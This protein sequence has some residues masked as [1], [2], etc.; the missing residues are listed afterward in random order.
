MGN[1]GFHVRSEL[2]NSSV[3]RLLLPWSKKELIHFT[4]CHLFTYF[5][6][7]HSSHLCL[8]WCYTHMHSV[9]WICYVWNGMLAFYA[10]YTVFCFFKWHVK[11]THAIIQYT[12]KFSSSSVLFITCM[13]TLQA[14]VNFLF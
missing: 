7:S 3:F 14:T 5:S 10:V 2:R 12:M 8:S 1:N 13:A 4:F 11:Y 9:S 6:L